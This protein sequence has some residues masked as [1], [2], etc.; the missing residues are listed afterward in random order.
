MKNKKIVFVF[1]LI[2]ALLLIMTSCVSASE[3][4]LINGSDN[5]PSLADPN[6]TNGGS[7]AGNN[8]MEGNNQIGGNNQ[9]K[10]KN[11]MGN[12]I[13]QLGVEEDI[14]LLVFIV[15]CIASA[16]YAYIKIRKYNNVH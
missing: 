13:I 8:E 10:G 11:Q 2:V 12:E 1:I 7:P 16:V 4:P 5:L 3:L 15:V 9:E 14:T 6:G